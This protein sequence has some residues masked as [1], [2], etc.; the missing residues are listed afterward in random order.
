MVGIGS[1]NLLDDGDGK[2]VENL[3]KLR[4]NYDEDVGRVF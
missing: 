4:E 1:R 2:Y 3:E